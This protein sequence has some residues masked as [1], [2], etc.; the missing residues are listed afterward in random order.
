MLTLKKIRTLALVGAAGAGLL[1]VPGN[2]RADTDTTGGG[3]EAAT[4]S[5]IETLRNQIA[6]LDE[7][8]RILERKQENADETN[9][10]AFKAIP[11][12]KADDKGLTV[13]SRDKSYQFRLRGLLQT[14]YRSY[15]DTEQN[16][17]AAAANNPDQNDGFVLR[18]VRPRFQ[19]RLWENLTFEFTPE[20]TWSNNTNNVRI[21]DTWA[22]YR[23]FDELNFKAGLFKTPV[24]LERFQSGA[25]TLF[26]ERGLSTNLVATRDLGAEINGV[27]W[28]KQLT[29]RL[30]IFNGAVDSDDAR[31]NANLD[32]G[33]D[34]AA[35]I[36]VE[37]FKNNGPVWV[38]G[39]GFGVAGSVGDNDGPFTGQ[40][41]LRY[42]SGGQDSFFDTNTANFVFDG[43]HYRINPQIYYYNGPWGF[44]GE[45]IYSSQDFARANNAGLTGTI[46]TSAWTAQLSYVVTGED[47][48]FTGVKPLKPFS[49]KEGGGFGA[50]ELGARIGSVAIDG[51]AFK[52]IGGSVLAATGSADEALAYGG[53]VNWYL[54]TNTKFQLSYEHTAYNGYLGGAGDRPDEDVITGRFQLSF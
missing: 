16:K 4:A 37:P 41:R 22:N 25:A 23:F 26:P 24:G 30:G 13:E 12:I 21:I 31:G 3:G 28:D 44:L 33:V 29:Y 42:R 10:A 27:T 18:R 19:G 38:Q 11:S 32:E 15:L 51:D 40:G 34:V 36:F 53:V 6:E 47:A 7:K 14:D 1:A 48:S 43:E 39:L 20:L 46:E 8:L 5:T 54:N 2:L 52:T 45:Y 49:L 35:G 17:S 50:V 9:T